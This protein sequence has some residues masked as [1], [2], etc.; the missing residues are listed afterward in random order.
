MTGPARS[1]SGERNGRAA[2][3]SSVADAWERFWFTPAESGS[4]A[5]VR[6][7]AA[8]I[9]LGLLWSYASDLQDWLG[10]T[11][12]L[13]TEM[14]REWRTPWGVSLF[15][16]VIAPSSV[17]A[18]FTATCVAFGLLLVG[19]ATPVVAP[20]CAVLWASLLH[21]APM[22]AGPAD[23]C[24]AVLLWCTAVGPAGRQW[25]IDRILGDRRGRPTPT[26]SVRARIAR[27]LLLVHA[28]AITVS[29]L[30]AQLKGD[31]WWDGMAA[32]YLASAPGC[33]LP[34]LRG[35]CEASEYFT[36]LVT[37]GIVVFE[38]AFA[39]GLWCRPMRR[40]VARIGLVCWPLVGL[41]AGEPF[42]GLAMAAFGLPAAVGDD[43]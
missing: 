24:L 3:V 6:I 25:S 39:A 12:V 43:A 31:A 2:A 15:D 10:P 42:W 13:P 21:R 19:L 22:L 35:A 7:A 8:G 4:L 9:G 29:T 27:G 41:F 5:F 14:V 18:L 38:V 26:P 32:W 30:V 16:W 37:H 20:L 17:A 1:T 28:S 33:R 36:N 23:D 34:W 11:G 40:P